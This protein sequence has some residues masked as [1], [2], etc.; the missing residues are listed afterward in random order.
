MEAYENT[1]ARQV[2]ERRERVLRR[3]GFGRTQEDEMR[4]PRVSEV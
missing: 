4:T 2:L 3:R 1:G